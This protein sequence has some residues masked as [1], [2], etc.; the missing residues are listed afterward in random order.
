MVGCYMSHIKVLRMLEP[1]DV[2]AVFEEDAMFVSMTTPAE[3]KSMFLGCCAR[4]FIPA[5]GKLGAQSSA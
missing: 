4:L 2:A 1:G 3:K 5:V